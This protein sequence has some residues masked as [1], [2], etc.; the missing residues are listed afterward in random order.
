M[1]GI[2]IGP[3]IALP[4]PRT[5]EESG[6]KLD[7]IVQLLMKALY[8]EGE[9][10]GLELAD[11]LGLAFSA[12]E[13]GIDVLK[14][15]HFCEIVGG[16]SL[17]P[18]S[19][20]YRISVHGRE[21]AALFLEHN[22]Y[23]GTAPVP[24]DQYLRYMASYPASAGQI[25]RRRVQQAFSHLVLSDR[26]LDQ[27]GPAVNAG[28]SLFVY[29]PPG[30][31]KTVISQAIRNLLI[32]EIWI[33]HALEINGSIVKVFDPVNHEALP[34]P[35]PGVGLEAMEVPDRRWVRCRRPLITVG[36]E[37]TLDALDL[38][39][40]PSAGFYRAP[41]QLLA[42][43]GVLVIDDFGRQRCS[44]QA[45]LNRWIV[46]LE[47]RVDYLTLQSGQKVALPFMVLPVFATNLKPS[48]L[49]DEAFLRR[50]QY[51]VLAENP[52]DADYRQIFE[53]CCREKDVEFD[54]SLVEYLLDNVYRPRQIAVRGCQPRDL[55]NQSL[56]LAQYRGEPRRLTTDLLDAACA[57]YF[58]DEDSQVA[59]TA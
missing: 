15:Q 20:R 30:N 49:V 51:K 45:L 34:A 31:G 21:R 17:G 13:P 41:I 42:N 22:M 54:P 59:P 44:P 27:L 5:L 19:Y 56:M 23:S 38:A 33:P 47:S 32:G 48:D 53:N 39:Y 11:R 4:T 18:P 28:H 1:T 26:V 29:G 58:V 16:T 57:T 46:C 36:G 43:G 6:L 10:S 50:I 3:L 12:I 8:F 25:S 7:L 24:L 52:S 35:S 2:D 14:T 9:S 40:N 55:I 37:L